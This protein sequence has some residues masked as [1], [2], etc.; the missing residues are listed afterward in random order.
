MC[1]KQKLLLLQS[2]TRLT[3]EHQWVWCCRSISTY[4]S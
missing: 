2:V 1:V 3:V 4:M